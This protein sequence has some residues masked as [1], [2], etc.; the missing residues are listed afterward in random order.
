MITGS[1]LPGSGGGKCFCNK[2]D[3]LKVQFPKREEQVQR[4]MSL[5]AL[6][7]AKTLVSQVGCRSEQDY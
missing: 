4:E 3:N 2:T 1:V 5:F 7:R 6:P